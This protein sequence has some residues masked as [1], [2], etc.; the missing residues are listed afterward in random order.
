MG[1]GGA[2]VELGVARL[3]LKVVWSDIPVFGE[4][5]TAAAYFH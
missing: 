4:T 2:G 3:T 5:D 1:G